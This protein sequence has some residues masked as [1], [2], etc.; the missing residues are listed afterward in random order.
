MK[1]SEIFNNKNISNRDK[2][3]TF[4]RNRRKELGITLRDFALQLNISP[5]YVSDIENGNRYAPVNYLEQVASIL[6]IENDELYYFYDIAGCTHGNWPDI[7][8]YLAKNPSARKALRL[9]RDKNISEQQLV[10]FIEQL[11]PNQEEQYL[12]PEC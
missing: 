1:P 5:A 7:N 11:K 12:E 10:Q 4:V 8:E 6:K 3:G 2:F 9:A